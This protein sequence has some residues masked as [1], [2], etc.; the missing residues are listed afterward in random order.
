MFSKATPASDASKLKPGVALPHVTLPTTEA[1][2]GAERGSRQQ[3]QPPVAAA[4]AA[5]R[6]PRPPPRVAASEALT[7]LPLFRSPCLRL[8]GRPRGDWGAHGPLAAGGDIPREAR[9][10]VRHVPGGAAGGWAGRWCLPCKGRAPKSR[11]MPS[12]TL[13]HAHASAACSAVCS[14]WAGRKVAD[15]KRQRGG[16]CPSA[17]PPS[18]LPVLTRPPAP[19][20]PCLPS[21]TS[22]P[23]PNRRLSPYSTSNCPTLPPLPFAAHDARI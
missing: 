15:G 10:A 1:S 7:M 18:H 8:P 20:W 23:P 5:A 2:V 17:G 13:A 22:C 21:S 9:P 16:C 6:A 19:P 12:S 11:H 4:P 3:V 14:V